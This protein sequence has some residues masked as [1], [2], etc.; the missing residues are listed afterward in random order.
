MHLLNVT[1]LRLQEFFDEAIPPY[2]IL[3][4]TW[5]KDEEEITFLELENGALQKHGNWYP[6]V[7]G[8]C[9]QAKKDQLEYVWLDTCC[10][11][12]RSSRELEEAIK[13]MFQW[14][15]KASVCYAYLSDVP[16]GDNPSCESSEFY[17]SRWFKRGW[18]LQEL[19]APRKLIF[20]DQTWAVL[21][22]KSTLA[23]AVKNIT[24]IPRPY[25]LG[26]LELNQASVAQR[27]SWAANRSTKR[28]ED[29]AYCLL[30]IFQVTNMRMTYGEGNKAFRQLQEEIIKKTR[31][32]SILAWGFN[33]EG[34]SSVDGGSGD[35]LSGGIFA[36]SPSDFANCG[37]ITSRQP[38]TIRTPEH[39]LE[40][41]TD[42]LRAYI[43][44]FTTSTGETYG[45]LNCGPKTEIV[46]IPLA[47]AESTAPFKVL[48]RP[49][50][51]CSIPLPRNEFPLCP[52]LAYIHIEPE[53]L[54]MNRS[55]WFQIDD[56]TEDDL[57][58]LDVHPRS[59]WNE[60]RATI[61]T[62]T[63]SHGPIFHR[64]L[65]RF[66]SKDE[67]ARD[68]IVLLD[69]ESQRSSYRPTARCHVMTCYRYLDL[70]DLS[71]KLIFM[72]KEAFGKQGASYGRLNISVSVSEEQRGRQPW[73]NVH[74]ATAPH[75]PETTI[76]AS[77]E[78]QQLDLRLRLV[79]NLH[80]QD[81]LIPEIDKLDQQWQKAKADLEPWTGRLADIEDELRRLNDERRELLSKTQTSSQALEQLT[82]SLSQAREQ[83]DGLLHRES[84]IYQLLNEPEHYGKNTWLEAMLR[85]M[86]ETGRTSDLVDRSDPQGFIQP[87]SRSNQ[88]PLSWAAVNGRQAFVKRLLE[89]GPI[90][91][92]CKDE[93]GRT[94]LALATEMGHEAIV[95]MLLDKGAVARID[96]AESRPALLPI[97]ETVEGPLRG[98]P[99]TSGRE[100]PIVNDG[101][102]V[103][104]I[105]KRTSVYPLPRPMS[106]LMDTQIH[107]LDSVEVLRSEPPWSSARHRGSS[108]VDNKSIASYNSSEKNMRTSI[109][110]AQLSIASS[111]ASEPLLFYSLTREAKHLE[112]L[113]TSYWR[114]LTVKAHSIYEQIYERCRDH[115]GEVMYSTFAAQFQSWQSPT[116]ET[117][118]KTWSR[119]LEEGTPIADSRQPKSLVMATLYMLHVERFH[120][121]ARPD[122]EDHEGSVPRMRRV[123]L[124]AFGHWVRCSCKADCSIQWN[125]ANDTGLYR[126]GGQA[127]NCALV[128]FMDR[129]GK[130]T[131]F[132]WGKREEE[133]RQRT[134]QAWVDGRKR[135]E[136]SSSSSSSS[137]PDTIWSNLPVWRP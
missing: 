34:S 72:R 129:G 52:S 120:P 79:R 44:M 105:S 127:R 80:R 99:L 110:S 11:D 4:H 109:S 59:L 49:Q 128:R 41:S 14:Y 35:V 60:D 29:I 86:L 90:D 111:H 113:A 40:V 117:I 1:T 15:E 134:W 68:V 108:V 66:R 45:L 76:D 123:R 47:A 85:R 58:L 17:S 30:G 38:D 103:R 122:A 50:G 53:D 2:A 19:L 62:P 119:L 63:A 118:A 131:V 135:A 24:G 20:Y 33:R 69:F 3:S 71:N 25:L 137:I 107:E 96:E 74:L 83:Q 54:G 114:Y 106:Q 104:P 61:A 91:I 87:P 75:L 8:L 77:F 132:G 12:K 101:L 18:T 121:S 81:N 115:R 5:G 67:Q 39:S 136:L 95:K 37:S 102:E 7:R 51:R 32:D 93:R 10:I 97:V 126:C 21:G 56:C 28:R 133:M 23:K 27:M 22:T 130:P 13:C 36:T 65:V 43:S 84:E 116:L 70:S 124:N 42:Y 100:A 48:I 31:D 92:N 112:P 26:S 64:A 78:L 9:E 6:K 46:G 98:Q 57:T 89:G 94:P 88:T 82:T 125:F 16:P 55:Y 73:F